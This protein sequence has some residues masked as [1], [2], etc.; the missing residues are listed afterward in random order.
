M[1]YRLSTLNRGHDP[2]AIIHNDNV[3]ISHVRSSAVPVLHYL[4]F[5]F[6]FSFCF[7]VVKVGLPM[8]TDTA[9]LILAHSWCGQILTSY[10]PV[11]LKM[12]TT[13]LSLNG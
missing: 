12:R 5:K 7:Q 8:Q 9:K 4:A 6:I 1:I 13:L 3:T 11:F 2:Y 10:I